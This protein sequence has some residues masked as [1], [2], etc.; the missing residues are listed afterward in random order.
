MPMVNK[1]SNNDD[2]EELIKILSPLLYKQRFRRY[3]A[4]DSFLNILFWKD[5]SSGYITPQLRQEIHDTLDTVKECGP[6]DEP[7]HIIDTEQAVE[8]ANKIRVQIGLK[9]L[10]MESGGFL[11]EIQTKTEA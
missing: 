9:Q 6:K 4:I 5:Y 3:F 10:K 1:M 8:V 11:S 7:Y 2:E